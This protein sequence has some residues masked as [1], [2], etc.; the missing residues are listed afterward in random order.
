MFHE[1]IE[2]YGVILHR[3]TKD[4][5]ELVRRWR[6]DPKISQYMSYRDYI[7]PEMQLRWFYKIN[8]N[9]NFYFI[10]EVD[11]KEIG[12]INVRDVD[13]EKGE[14]EPG[15]F[16]WDD[17]YL[18]ST[19]SFKAAF[20]L[21]DFCFETLGLQVLLIHVLKENKRAIQY[22]KAQGYVL[23]SDQEEVYN[24]EYKMT[25]ESYYQHKSKILKYL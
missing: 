8:N 12:C 11:G 23:S 9:H 17:A 22:N 14:G 10:I 25:A 1:K 20:A 13:Y 15:I 21:A 19:Y 3:L 5:I 7:T 18:N 6:N 4:K 24:Q 16:I 2:G